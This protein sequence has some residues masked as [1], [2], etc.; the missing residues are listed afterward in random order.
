MKSFFSKI[1]I[2]SYIKFLLCNYLMLQALIDQKKEYIDHIQNLLAIPIS[3]K[4]YGIYLNTQKKGLR[5]F[6]N[7]LNQISK[8]NNYTIE[9][10]INEIISKTKCTYI[11]KLL[12]VTINVCIKVKFYEYKSKLKYLKITFPKVQDFIHKCLINAAEF[13]WKNP[14]LFVQSNLKTVEIQNNL[15][16]IEFNVRKMIAKTI[17]ECINIQEIIEFLDEIMEASIEKKQKK[18]TKVKNNPKDRKNNEEVQFDAIKK[19]E[20]K[21]EYTGGSEQE[22]D[23]EEDCSEDEKYKEDE[24]D[25]EEDEQDEEEDEQDKQ[26]KQD[27]EQDEQDEQDK[28]DKQDKQDEQD[29]Q[30]D[31]ELN[32]ENK[33]LDNL[34]NDINEYDKDIIQ[35]VIENNIE[36]QSESDI[37]SGSENSDLDSSDISSDNETT[38]IKHNITDIKIVNINDTPIKSKTKPKRSSFF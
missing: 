22:N 36:I 18:L 26:D 24:Q 34:H 16:V 15:N 4:L 17:T 21:Y 29:E 33:E 7:E 3:E 20:V 10:E 32:K 25:E 2:F 13:A 14:Y 5:L 30:E 27:E 37:E 28:Q 35:D 8:W 23:G 1:C 19:D 31:E 6:Q 11:T 12:K 9:Q 38:E